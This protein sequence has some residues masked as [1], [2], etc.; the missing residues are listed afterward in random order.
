MNKK[1]T[2]ILA[3]V[4]LFVVAYYSIF[5]VKIASKNAEKKENEKILLSMSKDDISSF[6]YENKSR[7]IKAELIQKSNGWFLKSPVD[8]KADSYNIDT[9]LNTILNSKYEDK[10]ENVTNLDDFG[11]KAPKIVFTLN[12]KNGKK[13]FNVGGKNPTETSLY[14]SFASDSKLVY[15]IGESNFY[16]LDKTVYDLRD[17]SLFSFDREKASVTK[18]SN[19]FGDFILEKDKN[20]DW[21]IE[22][23]KKY[24]ADKSKMDSLFGKLFDEKLSDFVLDNPSPKDLDTYGISKPAITVSISN[25]KGINAKLFLGKDSGDYTYAKLDDKNVIFKVNKSISEVFKVNLNDLRSKNLLTFDS[26]A[27]T[28]VAIESKNINIIAEKLLVQD[29]KNKKD[30]KNN[31]EEK[32]WKFIKNDKN[33]K[34]TIEDLQAFVD[35]LSNLNFEKAYPNN[36][37]ITLGE[38]LINVSLTEEGKAEPIKLTFGDETKENKK[39]IYLLKPDVKDEVYSVLKSTLDKI[40]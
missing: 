35:K 30:N 28:K 24:K 12:T 21:N 26:S 38:N 22:S 32:T 33:S 23:P 4:L 31:K 5:E 29:D 37:K 10:I 39:Q 1:T 6:V 40:I 14:V 34:F 20:A 2:I 17:K 3:V 7:N 16:P 11:L 18:I 25:N 15:L 8:Y 36:D 13:V 19:S 27:I 9:I